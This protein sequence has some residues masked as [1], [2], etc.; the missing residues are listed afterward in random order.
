MLW[1]VKS[2][3]HDK[4]LTTTLLLGWMTTTCCIF[5]GL[6]AFH[7]Q[8]MTF[9]PSDK[10]VFMAMHIDTWGKWYALATFSL[11]NT[12]INEFIGSAMGPWF[13]NTIQ[14]QKT[15]YLDHSKL[16][17][18][19]ISLIY[20]IYTHV[21][22]IFSLYL[23]FSQIDFLLIRM[24]ADVTV[25]VFTTMEWMRNKVVDKDRHDSEWAGGASVAE[26]TMASE[27]RGNGELD[28]GTDGKE[29]AM[30]VVENAHLLPPAR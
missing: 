26:G 25:T 30:V 12:T 29:M 2:F 1:I 21:M 6:G 19:A 23:M 27:E 7:S 17:C 16:E 13:T 18:M 22:S 3:F 5:Y 28:D 9:G 10:T 14:D 15:R 11:M 8:F 24:M 20:D 4:R